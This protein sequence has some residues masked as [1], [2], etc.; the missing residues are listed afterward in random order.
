M[1]S[2]I[3]ISREFGS[4]GR[5][6]GKKL[7]ENLNIP[8]YDK[9]LL[10]MASKE[11]GICEELFYKNDESHSNSLLYSLVMG[12]YPLSADG[13]IHP[14]MPLNHK[15]FLA[16]FD[17]IKKIGEQGPCVIVGRCADY[18]LKD[19]KYVINFFINADI[20]SKKRRILERY[21]I[22]KDKVLD[23]IKKTDKNRANYYNY[24][25]DMRW[26]EAKNYDLCINS[27][28]VGIDGA[29]ELMKTYINVREKHLE[30]NQ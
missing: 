17:T 16:Q 7:A 12:T 4:G 3:T 11:S 2:I 19:Q 28:K 18:I 30:E 15:L 27:S 5:E 29:V 6:I 14:N 24:Y 26:G 21:D 8:F 20:L 13:K 25:S 1:K 22:D 10:E 9:E 23:F